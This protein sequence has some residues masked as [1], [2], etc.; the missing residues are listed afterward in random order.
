[1][2]DPSEARERE[3]E[4]DRPRIL[5]AHDLAMYAESLAT[6]LP[7]LR[8]DLR[9]H[10]LGPEELEVLVQALSHAIVICRRLTAVVATHS[11]GWILF[12]P[13]GENVLV[14]GGNGRSYRIEKPQLV[15]VLDAVD[16]LISQ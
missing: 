8:P 14:V 9:V 2:A 6:I 15:D 1:M 5:V 7:E 10:L 12:H 11:S 4:I 13:D 3:G 16:A